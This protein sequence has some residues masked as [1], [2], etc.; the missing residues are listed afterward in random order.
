VRGSGQG[1]AMWS[2]ERGAGSNELALLRLPLRMFASEITDAPR[3]A[4]QP[5]PGP[6]D[7]SLQNRFA[8][9]YL[10][11]GAGS[12]WRGGT[13]EQRI[14][15]TDVH[16]PIATAELALSHGVER[17]EVLGAH[18]LVV[19]QSGNDLAMSTLA[20]S[21]TPAVAQTYVQLGAAQG[22]TRSHGFFF[23]PD[24]DG[25]GGGVLGLP[26][27]HEEG[28]G[29]W[30]LFRESAAVSFM[31]VT[32]ELALKPL[33]ALGSTSTNAD[34]ACEVSCVDWYGNSRPIFYRDRVFALM[35]YELVEGRLGA[36][37]I[38][39]ISRLDYFS[40]SKVRARLAAVEKQS[41]SWW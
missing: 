23:L 21:E 20:L 13:S 6:S 14:F 1:D 33:G 10:I 22:E 28:G 40:R 32:P 30:S 16:D 41:S 15:V 5:L 8:G 12:A 4:Y 18:A 29:W 25:R 38:E 31:R 2:A 35:G 37:R 24:A 17:I 36:D 34:D 19:G 7:W 11:W 39:E 26:T 27:R 3:Y 9:R